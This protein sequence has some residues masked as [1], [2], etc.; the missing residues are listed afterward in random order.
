MRF[1]YLYNKYVI[2]LSVFHL[3]NH[4]GSNCV[5][6]FFLNYFS[7]PLFDFFFYLLIFRPLIYF[8]TCII[9]LA[10]I[11]KNG[12]ATFIIN[13]SKNEAEMSQT[14][15]GI[16]RRL[17]SKEEE[18]ELREGRPQDMYGRTPPPPQSNSRRRKGIP[19]RAPFGT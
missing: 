9:Q 11:R 7:Y 4:N 5:F 17:G 14:R 16:Q 12:D 18:E 2:M 10:G 6:H 13:S 15:E 3:V 8:F 19:H 1:Q